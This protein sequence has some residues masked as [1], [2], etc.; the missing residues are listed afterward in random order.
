[1]VG[2]SVRATRLTYHCSRD[3]RDAVVVGQA[4]AISASSARLMVG[5]PAWRPW[6]MLR[7]D[8]SCPATD[9]RNAPTVHR[10][11]GIWR[12]GSKR[13]QRIAF[14]WVIASSSASD[15]PYFAAACTSSSGASGH[16]ESECG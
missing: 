10:S 16:E 5:V 3:R 2:R 1:G 15:T 4:G 8:T 13:Y 7:I 11:R 14:S 9:E 6:S 12:N